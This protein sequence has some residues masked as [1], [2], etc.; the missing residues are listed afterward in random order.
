[1]CSSNVGALT[2]C[3]M[4]VLVRRLLKKVILEVSY[5]EFLWII[6][7]LSTRQHFFL[8]A[9]LH[10]IVNLSVNIINMLARPCK[11]KKNHLE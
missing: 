5:V 8:A 10:L 1:M 3:D 2:K 11:M 9:A 6:L 7:Y 4:K